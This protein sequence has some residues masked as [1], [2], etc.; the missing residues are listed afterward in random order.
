MIKC[1]AYG[2]NGNM[3]YIQTCCG[4]EHRGQDCDC[5]TYAEG[6]A[7]ESDAKV[8][9]EA[10]AAKWNVPVENWCSSKKLSSKTVVDYLENNGSNCPVCGSPALDGEEIQLGSGTAYQKIVC[11]NCQTSW[12]DNYKLT[13]IEIISYGD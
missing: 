6:I 12:Y 7:S 3:F 2:V 10:L 8:L 9:A 11:S 1:V 13:D 4:D 5:K